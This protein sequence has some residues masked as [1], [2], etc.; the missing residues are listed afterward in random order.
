[1]LYPYLRLRNWV[2]SLLRRQEGQALTEYELILILVAVA[3]IVV[4]GILGDEIVALFG[5]VTSEVEGAS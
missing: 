2:A 3:V 4:L 5:R 1:M